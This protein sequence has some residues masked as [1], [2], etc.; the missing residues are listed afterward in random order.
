MKIALLGVA[1]VVAL[2]VGSVFLGFVG[3]NNACVS[4]EQTL[5]AQYDQN[6]NNY[7]NFVKTVREVG[8]VPEMYAEDLKKVYDSA[9]KARYGADGSK[10]V[11]QFIKEHNP[12]LDPTMYTKI[13]Q[14][15][16][17]GRVSF[18]QD[19]KLLI[20]RKRDYETY[21]KTFPNTVYAGVL[22]FPK[23]DLSKFDIVTSDETEEAFKT[24]K[25]QPI[26]V[27]E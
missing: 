21:L 12:T 10:A 22:G 26:R 14:V 6:R 17:S 23:L 15:I 2:V 9:M 7:D 11:F 8:Q 27:R 5:K 24:K 16:E 13:Q 1:L 3:F 18:A 20:D 4:K 25:A 19:Q